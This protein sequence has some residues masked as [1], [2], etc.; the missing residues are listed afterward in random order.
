MFKTGSSQLNDA[1]AIPVRTMLYD[2]PDSEDFATPPPATLAGGASWVSGPIVSAGFSRIAANAKLSQAGTIS[3]QRYM[4]LE[5][6]VA[7]GA[8][9]TG[10]MVANV[11]KTVDNSADLNVPFVS[12]SITVH[13]TSGSSGNLTDV[14]ALIQS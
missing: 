11:D 8:V 5:G 14:A 4:D 12:F 6:T 10:V 3:I 1:N 7:I 2:V 9:I 13:N